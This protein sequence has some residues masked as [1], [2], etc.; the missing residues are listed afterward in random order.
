M[1]CEL[2]NADNAGKLETFGADQL[3]LGRRHRA[4]APLPE[5]PD[6]SDLPYGGAPRSDGTGR[7]QAGQG[8]DPR[9]KPRSR[10]RKV[11]AAARTSR[12]CGGAKCCRT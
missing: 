8:P 6:A 4:S 5:K 3:S 9:K 7:L 10:R 2:I 11:R 1:D 12:P